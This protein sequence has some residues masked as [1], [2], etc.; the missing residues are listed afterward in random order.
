LGALLT[1]VADHLGDITIGIATTAYVVFTYNILESGEAARRQTAEPYA[2]LRWYRSNDLSD[3]R[4]SLYGKLAE[5]ARQW[6]LRTLSAEFRPEEVAAERYLH[7]EISN[8][9]MAALSWFQLGLSAAA[10]IPDQKPFR[11]RDQ[12]RINNLNLREGDRTTIT[13][14]DLGPIPV[15]AAVSVRIETFVYGPVETEVVVDQY[16]GGEPYEATGVYPVG[17]PRA[18]IGP[19]EHSGE[20]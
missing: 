2:T 5:D 11:M 3:R 10:A 13:V 15:S 17:G 19:P 16:T 6:L 1:Y 18:E 7:I 9:R 12:L 14:S 20:G 4:L 8:A